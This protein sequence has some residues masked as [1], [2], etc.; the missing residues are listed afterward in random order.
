MTQ[1]TQT[2]PNVI[3]VDE[4]NTQIGVKPKLQAHIDGDLHRCF[5]ILLYNS[6]GEMLIHKRALEKYHCGGLWT[7][8]CCSHPAP[9]EHTIEGAKRRLYEEL[10]YKDITLTPQFEFIYLAEFE[11]GLIEHEYDFVY[12]GIVDFDPP[13]PDPSEIAEFAWVTVSELSAD[14]QENPSKYTVWFQIILSKLQKGEIS[15]VHSSSSQKDL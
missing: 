4:Q 5:S 6:K 15:P 13:K 11:N 2:E 14:V 3:L 1:V 10:G 8:A 9:G 12:T 7:N